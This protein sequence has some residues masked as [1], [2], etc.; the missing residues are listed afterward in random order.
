MTL[1]QVAKAGSTL[2]DFGSSISNELEAELLTGKQLNLERA[3]A[4]ALAGD[5][6]TLAE[7]L[8]KNMGTAAEFTK[9]NK[10]QQDSL[11]KSIGMSSDELA[12]TLRKREEALASGKSLAQVTEEEAAKAL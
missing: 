8:A 10:L 4:A 6:I 3:R 1:E 2:L 9:L 7:E 5:Q 12:E 11:A